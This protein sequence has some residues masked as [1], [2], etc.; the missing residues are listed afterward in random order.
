MTVAQKRQLTVGIVTTVLGGMLLLA[1]RSLTA[2]VML[3]PEVEARFLGVEAE[4]RET[5]AIT[6]DHLCADAP[7]HW[8]CR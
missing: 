2:Q 7:N 4:L 8:R 5:K 1:V 6:L 3:R